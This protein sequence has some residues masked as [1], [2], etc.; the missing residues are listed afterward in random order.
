RAFRVEKDCTHGRLSRSVFSPRKTSI[1]D[2]L[3]RIA[4]TLRTTRSV[5]ELSREH[6]LDNGSLYWGKRFI[7]RRLLRSDVQSVRS[8]N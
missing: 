1:V 3:T 5:A 8:T 4:Q 6:D 2:S 7:S